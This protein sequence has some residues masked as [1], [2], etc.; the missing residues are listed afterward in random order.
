MGD[1]KTACVHKFVYARECVCIAE[2]MG[3]QLISVSSENCACVVRVYEMKY[4]RRKKKEKRTDVETN[5]F[6]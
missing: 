1:K 4:S 2:E 6:R 5:N 3:K